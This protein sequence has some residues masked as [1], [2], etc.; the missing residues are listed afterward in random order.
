MERK[1][2]LN[3][4]LRDHLTGYE[5]RFEQQK[6]A[7]AVMSALQKKR[8]ILVEAGTGVG[9]SLAY[10]IPTILWTKEKADGKVVIS[11]YTKALQRQLYEKDLPFLK[12][13]LFPEVKYALCL[14]SDNYL[15]LRRLNQSRQHGLFE[16]DEAESLANL[17]RWSRLTKKG[18]R[19]EIETED[20]LW[21]K[22][23]RESDLCHGKE[24][25]LYRM[26]FYQKA[27]NRERQSQILIT[28]H[29]LFFAHVASGYN[30]LPPFR[31]IVFDE[32]HEIED[33]ASD[34]LGIEVSNYRLRH[35]FDSV[36][37]SRGKGLLSRLKWLDNPMFDELSSV[38]NAAR[39]G[40]DSFFQ[41]IL[42]EMDRESTKRIREKHVVRDTITEDLLRLHNQLKYLATL[43]GDEEERK[44]IEAISNRCELMKD[45]IR[46]F[47]DQSLEEAVYWI[48][49]SKALI[50]VKVTP[51][52]IS[53]IL[54]KTVFSTIDTSILTSA[55]LSTK[56]E[57]SYIKERIGM[58]DGDEILLE[59]PFHYKNQTLLYIPTDIPEPR[60]ATY[61]MVISERVDEIVR[62]VQSKTMVLFTSYNLLHAVADMLE[63]NIEILRQGEL[64]NYRL[65]ERF[66]VS[67]KAVL[68]GTYTFWQ[69]VD[70][71]GDEL[72]CLVITKLPFGVPN[73]PVTEGRM[74]QII[75]SGRDPFYTYQVPQAIITLRQ[76]FGRLIRTKKDRGVVAI[77]DSRIAKKPYG[78]IFLK[79]LPEVEITDKMGDMEKFLN[80]TQCRKV[81]QSV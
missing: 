44:E 78:R 16:Q 36:I 75:H 22:V 76:G 19:G 43:S 20:S 55:T 6:M 34:Y 5:C 48:D 77:L 47:L 25:K 60:D 28:N 29:H 62:I 14:G 64:D 61:S 58:E 45:S 38:V 23:G 42:S 4:L 57:F 51:I 31:G 26:C 67:D 3:N 2:D 56:G 17:L 21:R 7:E 49:Y 24:C 59:S 69:G 41:G 72:R 9:K 11:T 53:E 79:S 1:L 68:F 13:T 63:G 15:C 18:I 27:K 46:I 8:N 40:A 37:S 33:V 12:S 54:L 66:K 35:L 52:N 81:L 71:P 39:R 80:N 73:D 10:L 32:A 74:E 70:F 50:R 65:I 30:V